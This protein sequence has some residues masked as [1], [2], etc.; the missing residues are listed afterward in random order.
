MKADLDGLAFN[1]AAFISALFLLEYGA[2][3]FVDHA[4]V[5]AKR[6]GIPPT[7]IALLTAGA[8]WEEVRLSFPP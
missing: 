1:V 5:I 7:I 3:A 4:A 2:D 6:T 8:E